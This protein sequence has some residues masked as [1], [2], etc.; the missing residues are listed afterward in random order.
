MIIY[1]TKFDNTEKVAKALADGM[2]ARVYS[3]KTQSS[4]SSTITF[5][6]V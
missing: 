3:V 5:F 4:V 2:E 1:D 6:S